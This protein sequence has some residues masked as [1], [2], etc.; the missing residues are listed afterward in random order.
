MIAFKL[1]TGESLDMFP[2]TSIS[3]E[4]NNPLFETDVIKGTY[5]YP[6]DFPNTDANRKNLGFPTELMNRNIAAFTFQ[7]DMLVE[8]ILFKQGY[9]KI[10]KITPKRITAS[11]LAGMGSIMNW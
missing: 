10:L 11:F 4:I 6:F 2:D 5:T 7:V 1:S 3:L 8:G 9:L